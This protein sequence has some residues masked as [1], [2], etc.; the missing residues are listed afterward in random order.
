M[1]RARACHLKVA[2]E[3]RSR[4]TFSRLRYADTIFGC[5][6]NDG[7]RLVLNEFALAY[8]KDHFDLA[9]D[10][11]Q[12]DTLRYGGRGGREPFPTPITK[13]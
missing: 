3:L 10:V 11:E 4:E 5:L 13:V 12:E 6:D 8:G 9:S 7:A 2:A 1:R